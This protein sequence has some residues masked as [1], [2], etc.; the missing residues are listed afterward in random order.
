MNRKRIFIAVT[1]V[2]MCMSLTAPAYAAYNPF[3]RMESESRQAVD[4]AIKAGTIPP[5]TTIY[6][7][8]YGSNKNGITIVTR[9]HD[10]NGNWVAARSQTQESNEYLSEA[11]IEMLSEEILAEYASEMFR[12][13]NLERENAG[14]EPLTRN[15]LLDGAAMIR[16]SEVIIVD[17]AEGAPHTR[18]DGTS[19]KDMLTA[20][21]LN[22]KRCGEN[23]ARSEA[24]PQFAIEAWLRSDGHRENILREDYGSIG[25]GVYQLPDGSL[26]WVQIFM[27]K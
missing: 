20:M 13:T 3:A 19:Y 1:A 27:L 10:Q 12:L 23:I 4:A 17:K 18:P 25:I 26:D 24:T 2:V 6:D 11:S 15:S 16:A 21:G 7:C 5:G 14:L 8:E 9:Y 22:G